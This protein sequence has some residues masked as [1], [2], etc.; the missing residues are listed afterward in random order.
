MAE[1]ALKDAE[2]AERKRTPQAKFAEAEHL[3]EE[4]RERQQMD[5]TLRQK[6]A[7]EKALLNAAKATKDAEKAVKDS[8]IAERKRICEEKKIKHSNL[9]KQ[10]DLK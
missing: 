7:T 10:G 4:K 8:G 2:I 9:Q 1:K 3:T 5:I 6:G